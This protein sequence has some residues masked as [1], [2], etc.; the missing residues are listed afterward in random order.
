MNVSLTKTCSVFGHSEIKISDKLKKEIK[1]FI[2]DLIVY[3]NYEFFLFGGFGDFDS[4]CHTIVT[5][6]KSKYPNIKRIY[7]LEDERYLNIRKRPK[8]LKDTFYENFV[9]Y[10]LEFNWWYTRIY[11]RNC[12]MI[13]RSDLIIFFVNNTKKNSGAYKSYKYALKLHKNIKNFGSIGN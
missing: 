10:M 13:K 7:C 12:E 9:Y 1:N 4:L 11:Y 6:L 8:Y 5:E 2:E 3:Q